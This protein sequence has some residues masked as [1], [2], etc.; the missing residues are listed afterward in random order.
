MISV[1][2]R[3]IQ[4][5]F[6]LSET[7]RLLKEA[8]KEVASLKELKKTTSSRIRAA[9]SLHKD[10]EAG[11]KVVEHQVK[12]FEVKFWAEQDKNIELS[13][14]ED[15]LN[16]MLCTHVHGMCLEVQL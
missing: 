2:S 1:C 7:E 13:S 5:K 6:R 3:H 10:V 11:L 15:G 16:G 12:E 4:N 14:L 8:K 9:E